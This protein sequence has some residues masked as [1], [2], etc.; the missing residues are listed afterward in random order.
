MMTGLA[1]ALREATAALEGISSTPRLDAELLL[2]HALGIDF[3]FD[4]DGSIADAS[5]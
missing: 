5:H 2:A 4:G 3:D 1:P